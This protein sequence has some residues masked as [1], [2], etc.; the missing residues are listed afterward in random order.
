MSGILG[1]IQAAIEAV[2]FPSVRVGIFFLSPLDSR[3]NYT[4]INLCSE[5]FGDL[6]N[7]AGVKALDAYLA[8]NSYIE[9]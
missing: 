4:C 1:N 6:K 7:P 5:M 3:F 9:G 8:E 2:L